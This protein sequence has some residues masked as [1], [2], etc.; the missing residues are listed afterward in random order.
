MGD[1][2]TVRVVGVINVSPEPFYKGSMK[3]TLNEIV[4]A[5]LTM[6][7]E[8]ADII[9]IGAMSTAPYLEIEI[10]VE[11]EAKRLASAVSAVK[12]VVTISL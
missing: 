9:D 7:D 8:G 1:K 3:M 10:S 6:V 11:E 4:A 2:Y 5:A 12:G